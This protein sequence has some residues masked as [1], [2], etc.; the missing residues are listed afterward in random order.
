MSNKRKV[1]E[2]FKFRKRNYYLNGYILESNFSD[3]ELS[4][5]EAMGKIEAKPKEVK[6]N[7]KKKDSKN[8]SKD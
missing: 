7:S 4:T 8:A 6:K 1:L 3:I 5:L 2:A